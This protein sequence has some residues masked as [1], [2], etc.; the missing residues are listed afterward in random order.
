MTSAPIVPGR[1]G[2][3]N[4]PFQKVFTESLDG[5]QTRGSQIINVDETTVG[6]TTTTYVGKAAKGSSNASAVWKIQKVE[7]NTG[8]ITNIR[9]ASEDYDQIW[10]NRTTLTYS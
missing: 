10:D 6:T 1:D 7:E 9:L 2:I 8:G 5:T 4:G 3:V